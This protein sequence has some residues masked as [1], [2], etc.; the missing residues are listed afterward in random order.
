MV[1][2]NAK[3]LKWIIKKR[4]CAVWLSLFCFK[5]VK[6]I[7]TN[8]RYKINNHINTSCWLLITDFKILCFSLETYV[9]PTRR[10][11]SVIPVFWSFSISYVATLP[12]I[13]L[14]SCF[15][16]FAYSNM[17]FSTMN[18][19]HLFPLILISPIFHISFP[20]ILYFTFFTHCL[21]Y[22]LTP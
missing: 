14:T 11:S 13:S 8:T 6:Y 22:V 3:L 17:I 4:Y 15:F 18:F 7:S 5:I 10:C 21:Y 9:V 2:P 19:N 12:Y 1:S 16:L 20:Y